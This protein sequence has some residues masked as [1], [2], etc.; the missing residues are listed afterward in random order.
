MRVLITVVFL[1]IGLIGF[2]QEE[3]ILEIRTIKQLQYTSPLSNNVEI[4]DGSRKWII[5]TDAKTITF[6]TE[7]SGLVEYKYHSQKF[8]ENEVYFNCNNGDIVVLRIY[9]KKNYE[10]LFIG[11]ELEGE[12]QVYHYTTNPNIGKFK[13]YY[14]M[15]TQGAKTHK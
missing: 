1:L 8:I 10:I 7:L 6:R 14:D 2:S 12:R 13:E 4:G 15:F 3:G 9:S 11:E 5:D